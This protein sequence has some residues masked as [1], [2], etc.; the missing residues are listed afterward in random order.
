MYPAGIHQSIPYQDMFN[1]SGSSG[2][3]DLGAPL[4][5]LARVRQVI[6][7]GEVPFRHLVYLTGRPVPIPE[8]GPTS[9]DAVFPAATA[10]IDAHVS[11]TSGMDVIGDGFPSR[12]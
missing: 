4:S 7:L 5:K 2:L 12:S 11:A 6:Q 10:G 8:T 3:G 9:G 1:L